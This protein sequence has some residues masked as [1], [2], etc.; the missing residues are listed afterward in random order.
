MNLLLTL[1]I[2]NYIQDKHADHSYEPAIISTVDD[3]SVLLPTQSVLSS[4]AKVI[5]PLVDGYRDSNLED[6]INIISTVMQNT[7][8]C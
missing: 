5:K 3:K 7:N 8:E 6:W 4:L 1:R 2:E